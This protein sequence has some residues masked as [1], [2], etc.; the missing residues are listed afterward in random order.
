MSVADLYPEHIASLQ[1]HYDQL[2]DQQGYDGLLIGSGSVS[3]YFL[4]DHSVP[5]KTSPQLQAWLPLNRHPECYLLLQRGQKPQLF[6]YN[7]TDFWHKPAGRPQGF[8]TAYF[9]I[10]E[11]QQ[12]S[13]V[14]SYL[15]GLNNLAFAGENEARARQWGLTE[16]NP[17]PLVAAMHWR[18]A[19]KSDYEIECLRRATTLAVAGHRAAAAEFEAGGSEFDIQMAYLAASGQREQELPYGNIV[20]LNENAAIL[21]YQHYEKTRPTRRH[22]FLIDAGASYNGYASDITRTYSAEQGL[23]SELIGALDAAHLQLIGEIRTGRSFVDLHLAMVRSIATLL[24]QFGLVNASPDTQL[25]QGIVSTFFPH[26]LGHL[27]GLQVHD[28]G[29]LQADERGTPAPPPSAHPFLR[30]TR[31]LEAGMVFT[32]EPGIYFIDSLLS[33]LKESAA[34]AAVNWSL[35]D[36][37]RACGGIRIEDNVL[38]TQQGTENLTR[39]AFVC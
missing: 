21:H 17:Q 32:V 9:D 4:D 10:V 3:C 20:A 25:E 33:R 18:R 14:D 27:L 8:W 15:S 37:L 39:N 35:V 29:G 38:L 36:S 7:P 19:V 28:V 13:D 5:F 16:I 22:A 26:G 30:L 34:G 6:Y 11:I 23:F 2:L 24:Q 12:A 1:R 31:T